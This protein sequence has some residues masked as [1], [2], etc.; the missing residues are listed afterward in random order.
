MSHELRTPLNAIIGYSE[1]LQEAG[2]GRR[3]HD[4][5]IP[6]LQKIHAAGK[7]LL[8]LIN[9]ILDLSKI[10][11]GKMEL[12]LE[13]FDVA[14][15][16]QD[17][18]ATVQPLVE[19]NGNTLAVRC[20]ADVGLHARRPDARCGRSCSTCSATPASSPST[21]RSRWRS[22]RESAGG[23]DWMRF[24]VDGHRHRHD[25]RSSSS[26]CS[27]SSRRSTPR[28]RA[29]TAAPGSGWRSAGTSADMMGGD[30]T[31]DSEPGVRLD[32][33]AADSGEGH[34]GRRT[35]DRPA[36]A[37][38]RSLPSAIAARGRGDPIGPI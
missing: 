11:A 25:R 24:R 20:G 9:D 15:L 16:V 1:M 6:D 30:I 31:V 7:H 8:A 27:R 12:F 29:S 33:H 3:A 32:V 23:S 2:R 4:D 26:G 10:E 34:V 17:V 5:S 13:T 35:A 28:R 37:A 19:K 36:T 14:A 21:A 18:A 22:T 38:W